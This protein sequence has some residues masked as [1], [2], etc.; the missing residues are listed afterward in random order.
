MAGLALLILER[1]LP[2]AGASGDLGRSIHSAIGQISKHV[3]PGAVTPADIKNQMEQL[4]LRQ[5]QFGAQMQRMRAQAAQQGGGT[6]AAA[7]AAPQAQT[8]AAPQARA[9]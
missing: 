4:M 1:A 9:A 3:P 2:L 7:P 6:P 8:G 5:Q